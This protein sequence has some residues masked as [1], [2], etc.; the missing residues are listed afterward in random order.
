[1]GTAEQEHRLA[2]RVLLET[3]QRNTPPHAPFSRENGSSC[4]G[5]GSAF[6]YVQESAGVT[7][8][9]GWFVQHLLLN[10]Q[11]YSPEAKVLTHMKALQDVQN[12]E[13]QAGHLGP[14]QN[15]QQ[16]NRATLLAL[17]TQK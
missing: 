13:H 3:L 15:P 2:L 14:K 12:S 16:Q 11:L 8:A 6:N 9:V 17:E 7:Q 1:M 10:S 4:D 5:G